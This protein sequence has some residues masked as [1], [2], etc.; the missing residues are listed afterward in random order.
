MN[1]SEAGGEIAEVL[2]GPIER[3]S[4]PPICEKVDEL[5]VVLLTTL[6]YELVVLRGRGRRGRAIDFGYLLLDA[7]GDKAHVRR[8]KAIR[9]NELVTDKEKEFGLCSIQLNACVWRY[10]L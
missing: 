7:G 4:R 5:L 1:R 9:R 8:N 10:W 3:R 6:S 2:L